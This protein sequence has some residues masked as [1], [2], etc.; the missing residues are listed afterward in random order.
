MHTG[1]KTIKGT[2]FY[3]SPSSGRA[4]KGRTY[5]INGKKY[6]FSSGGQLIVTTE[7][8]VTPSKPDTP[9][10]EAPSKP[11]TP[12]TEAPSTEATSKHETPSTE[13]PSKPETPSTEAPSKP[14][15]PSTEKKQKYTY[16]IER[17]NPNGYGLYD[18]NVY[19][20]YVK[21]EAPI[22]YF[23]IEGDFR[24][25]VTDFYDV[26]YPK[27][28]AGSKIVSSSVPYKDGYLITVSFNH[29]G[30]QKITIKEVGPNGNRYYNYI[31][32]SENVYFDVLDFDHYE[33]AYLRKVIN[34]VTTSGMTDLEKVK[35][36]QEYIFYNFKYNDSDTGYT[37]PIQS[38]KELGARFET[39]KI[40]C[41]DSTAMMD[42]VADIIGLKWRNLDRTSGPWMNAAPGHVWTSVF[43]DSEWYDVDAC[44]NVYS[45]NLIDLDN[46][47]YIN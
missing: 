41:T 29:S 24:T 44:P 40:V 26:R 39:K 43:Y 23:W 34:N 22:D 31:E 46:V 25:I 2:K 30:H 19:V 47:E 9:S 3:F 7:K 18:K 27:N 12:S 10:T 28:A 38:V 21:T 4:Y 42:K 33:E 1:W 8:P 35:A 13:T 17:Y 45:G 15:T 36:V 6:R 20:L 16:S 11:E 37:K 14:E 5:T 32:C